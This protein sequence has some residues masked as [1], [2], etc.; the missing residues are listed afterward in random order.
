MIS[1]VEMYELA[2]DYGF[3][4]QKVNEDVFLLKSKHDN[5][6]VEY[7]Y[8]RARPFVLKHKNKRHQIH[9]Y[10]YQHDFLDLPKALWSMMTHDNNRV[11]RHHNPLRR[12]DKLLANPPYITLNKKYN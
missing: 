11:C 10:H 12:I 9:K 4:V 7:Q 8:G 3:S 2:R 6:M 1:E 5:W